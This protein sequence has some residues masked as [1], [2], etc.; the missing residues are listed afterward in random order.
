[1]NQTIKLPS[2]PKSRHGGYSH[3]KTGAVPL[4]KKEIERYLSGLRAGYVQD[5]GP[6]EEDLTTGKLLLLNKLITLEG[7][8]RCVEIQAAR[9]GNLKLLDLHYNARNNL[10]VKIA[11]CLGINHRA[12]EKTLK[13]WELPDAADP[14]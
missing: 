14:A 10:I 6:Q 4:D 12:S 8:Q 7:C 13:P 2:G 5:L 9:D 11:L 1:M 3:M